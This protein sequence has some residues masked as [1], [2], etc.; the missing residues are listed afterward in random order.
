MVRKGRCV[1]DRVLE[2]TDI[3]QVMET[4]ATTAPQPEP[5]PGRMSVARLL[6]SYRESRGMSK[7]DLAERAGMN[8]SSITRFEQGSRDPERET[9]LQLSKAMMLPMI[10]RDRLLAA[11]GY[12]SEVWDDPLLVELAQLIADPAVPAE[13]REQ[14]RSVVSTLR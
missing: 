9:I 10:D 1:E 14:A 3:A 6:A 4:G 2:Q 12:R 7:A 11:A 5:A 8:P 13:A